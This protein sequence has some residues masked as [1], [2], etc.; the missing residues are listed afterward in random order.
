VPLTLSGLD[1][2]GAGPDRDLV[3]VH[4][5]LLAFEAVDPRAAKVVELRFFGGL[6][7]DEIAQ[8]LGV[9]AATV[10]RDWS[11]ARAWLHRA[12]ASR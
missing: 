11:L 12:L 5:A 9:S 2:L 4:E 1:Q 6:E 10:K 8:A 7:N 3:A